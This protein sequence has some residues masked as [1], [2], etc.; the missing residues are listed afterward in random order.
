DSSGAAAGTGVV[1][2]LGKLGIAG[3][4][5][6]VNE[7]C[8]RI[9]KSVNG[10]PAD[11]VLMKAHVLDAQEVIARLPLDQLN[12]DDTK[13]VVEMVLKATT[14]RTMY[15]LLD[16]LRTATDAAPTIA[17]K[18]R[19]RLLVISNKKAFEVG[20]KTVNLLPLRLGLGQEQ[21]LDKPG[22]HWI[23]LMYERPDGVVQAVQ[24]LSGAGE[25]GNST[26]PAT[27]R[28][29]GQT[30]RRIQV[31]L[32]AI[33]PISARSETTGKYSPIEPLVALRTDGNL[34]QLFKPAGIRIGPGPTV[35]V[36]DI[37]PP[38]LEKDRG[39]F[40]KS[41]Q[42]TYAF[43]AVKTKDGL[44]LPKGEGTE[45]GNELRRSKGTHAEHKAIEAG[46]LRRAVDEAVKLGT[47]ENPA[48]VYIAVSRSGCA[49]GNVASTGATTCDRQIVAAWKAEMDRLPEA[50]KQNI[51]PE[52][53]MH[54]ATLYGSNQGTANATDIGSLKLLKG[55]RVAVSVIT[56]EDGAPTPGGE[57]LAESV[58]DV[59]LA[60]SPP[61]RFIDGLASIGSS[62]SVGGYRL[63]PN[64]VKAI[65]KASQLAKA[66]PAKLATLDQIATTLNSQLH[67]L[68]V[69]IGGA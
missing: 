30:V 19:I 7:L 29:R 54:V 9:G 45:K 37:L 6:K 10:V 38:E 41:E 21:K 60:G 62:A 14:V 52:L 27:Q 64:Q 42:S 4:V 12:P 16:I 53:E 18:S 17:E 33:A 28:L 61:Q 43:I 8:A 68:G 3:A 63:P 40:I 24:V 23:D 5:A 66:D 59:D 11:Q 51:E 65:A 22:A 55:G 39:R 26:D 49:G 46:D 67:Q 36:D 50:Q 15:R 13:T 1:E 32:N 35:K 56:P 25:L 31:T 58:R 57:Q 34:D 44:V 69:C 47:P 20:D 2:V 48:Q